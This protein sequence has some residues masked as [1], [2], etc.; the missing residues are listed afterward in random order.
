MR[1]VGFLLLAVVV[2]AGPRP[3]QGQTTSAELRAQGQRCMQARNFRCA[4]TAYNAFVA[5]RPTDPIGYALRGILL[6]RMEQYARGAADLEKAMDLGEG[7]YDIFA[8][9]A[10][11]LR[12]GG[13]VREAIDWSYRALEVV[14]GLLDVRGDLAT[15]LVAET[16]HHEALAMLAGFDAGRVA[17][18]QTAYFAAR[19]VAIEN[20]LARRGTVADRPDGSLRLPKVESFF[21]APV[22]LGGGRVNALIVDT[23]AGNMVLPR[24]LLAENK[25]EY[26]ITR[27]GIRAKMAD[28]RTST[29]D[30]A[31][32]AQVSVG[33][34]VLKDVPAFVCDGCMALLGQEVLS[35]FDLRSERVQWVEFMTL[36][37]RTPLVR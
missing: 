25:V 29:G 37:Q 18:G 27:P 11:A 33:P 15:M 10:E 14:P 31:M 30:M 13:R 5:Q 7:T 8:F 21:Y 1:W 35:R 34:F 2:A 24:A 16:W 9:Y 32:L 19:R 20:A 4:E 36:T 22:V 17:K 23:G 26:R 28:G 6:V 3:A 12:H